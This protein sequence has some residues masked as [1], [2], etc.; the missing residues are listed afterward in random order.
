MGA[1]IPRACE[2]HTQRSTQAYVTTDVAISG[3][4]AEVCVERE[5]SSW[6]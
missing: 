4:E 2:L 5:G 6:S 3:R 1:S